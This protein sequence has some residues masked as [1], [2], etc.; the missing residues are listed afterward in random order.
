VRP[1]ALAL[2][3]ALLAATGSARAEGAPARATF[4]LIVGVNR[5]VDEDERP[6]R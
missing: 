5:S 2:A 6:L 3:A 4:A 1:A